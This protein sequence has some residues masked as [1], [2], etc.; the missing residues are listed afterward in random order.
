MKVE[1]LLFTRVRF[2]GLL[3]STK[4]GRTLKEGNKGKE[5]E[6]KK[7]RKKKQRKTNNE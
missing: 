4:Y 1:N 2:T 6:T 7:V 3:H 5:N